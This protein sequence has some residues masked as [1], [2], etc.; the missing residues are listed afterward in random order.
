MFFALHG[1]ICVF[2]RY[3]LG[4]FVMGVSYNLLELPLVAL[5]LLRLILRMIDR[6]SLDELSAA[7]QL[8]WL[9][10]VVARKVALGSFSILNQV[11]KRKVTFYSGRRARGLVGGL[12]YLLGFRYGDVRKQNE[13]ADK[14]G[15]TD[16]TIRMSYRKWLVEFPDLFEDVIGMMA[17]DENLKYFVLIDLK[18]AMAK[19]PV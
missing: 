3:F 10:K 12:F 2:F 5:P 14:L 13:L 9:D 19:R 15:T 1:F 8:V 7:A 16:V 11:Y 17:Q 18:Q 4:F 6:I